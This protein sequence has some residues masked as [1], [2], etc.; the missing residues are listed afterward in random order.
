MVRRIEQAKISATVIE[1]FFFLACATSLIA[2]IES[3]I[4][5]G[6]SSSLGTV[7]SSGFWGAG[8]KVGQAW[9]Q[10]LHGFSFVWPLTH[11]TA[12]MPFSLCHLS[13]ESNSTHTAG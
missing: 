1:R 11:L 2:A 10:N 3:Q 7:V 4:T 8:L 9:P 6:P 12:E 13:W 5:A